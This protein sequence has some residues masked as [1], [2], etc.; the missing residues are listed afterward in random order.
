MVESPTSVR[1]LIAILTIAAGLAACDDDGSS[2]G[3]SN[4]CADSPELLDVDSPDL[5]GDGEESCD[6]S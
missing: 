1:T 5:G 3:A 6:G 2:T 4:D